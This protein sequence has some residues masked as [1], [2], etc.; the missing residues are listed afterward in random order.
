MVNRPTLS[1]LRLQQWAPGWRSANNAP[2]PPEAK[3]LEPNLSPGAA[4]TC[5][6]PKILLALLTLQAS[7]SQPSGNCYGYP[8]GEEKFGNALNP[9]RG[10]PLICFEAW[11][12]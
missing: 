3:T 6:T 5:E 1:Q 4:K 10:V 11:D 12:V 7:K 2:A 8:T 9:A